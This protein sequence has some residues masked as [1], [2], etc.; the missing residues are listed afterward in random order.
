MKLNVKKIK[1][2]TV[3][4][5]NIDFLFSFDTLEKR[6]KED[7]ILL[8]AGAANNMIIIFN[9]FYE[10]S[11]SSKRVVIMH[12]IGHILGNKTEKDADKFAI[13]NSSIEMYKKS[14]EETKE[15]CK[16]YNILH[17]TKYDYTEEINKRKRDKNEID[18]N[19]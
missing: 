17:T 7:K 3:A 5:V 16:K 8:F 4:G 10:L 9:E 2:I 12:E 13:K 18:K 19:L 6:L 1:T 15:I 14:V 11:N